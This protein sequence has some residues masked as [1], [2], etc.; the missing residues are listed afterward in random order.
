TTGRSATTSPPYTVLSVSSAPPIPLTATS[1][2]PAPIARVIATLL[3]P[4][5]YSPADRG[6]V[7]FSPQFVTVTVLPSEELTGLVRPSEH[8]LRTTPT[9]NRPTTARPPLAARRDGRCPGLGCTRL[10]TASHSPVRYHWRAPGPTSPMPAG[11]MPRS[12]SSTVC[13]VASECDPGEGSIPRSPADPWLPGWFST[14]SPLP[15]RIGLRHHNRISGTG[16]VCW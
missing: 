13:R 7:T 3:G 9:V 2:S 14:I 11:A 10:M 12:R 16:R 15:R 4:L 1:W 8:P 6:K 5:T